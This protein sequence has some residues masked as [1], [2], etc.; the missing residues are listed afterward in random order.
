M[1]LIFKKG[2]PELLNTQKIYAAL[3]WLKQ[4]ADLCDEI[5][6]FTA[7][8]PDSAHPT[9][10]V[11]APVEWLESNGFHTLATA[12]D[13]N[14]AVRQYMHEV[15]GGAC[16][17]AILYVHDKA[18]LAFKALAAHKVLGQFRPEQP[19]LFYE[20]SLS[21]CMAVAVQHVDNIPLIQRCGHTLSGTGSEWQMCKTGQED[22]MCGLLGI[23]T[24]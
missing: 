1:V 22:I 16:R 21:I 6:Q 2:M 10:F 24:H 20:K 8:V 7:L 19:S 9:D 11:T 5:S 12:G 15:P 3:G 14:S 17:P 18:C 13:P 4:L 23:A